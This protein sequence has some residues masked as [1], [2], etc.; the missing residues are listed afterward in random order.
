MA[1]SQLVVTSSSYFLQLTQTSR[2]LRIELQLVANYRSELVVARFSCAE[3]GTDQP[4]L[5]LLISVRLQP[6]PNL[7]TSQTNLQSDLRLQ[8]LLLGLKIYCYSCYCCW[9]PY[10]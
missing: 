5:I 10:D 1:S 7:P 8:C 6:S 3:V 9:S 2:W 4:Q